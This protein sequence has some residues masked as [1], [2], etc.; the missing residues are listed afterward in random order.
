MF[1]RILALLLWLG[2]APAFAQSIQG[3]SPSVIGI[4]GSNVT[5]AKVLTLPQVQ[6]TVIY[7]TSPTPSPVVP[8][9][10][11]VTNWIQ[12]NG[13]GAVLVEA[14]TNTFS[15]YY[16]VQFSNNPTPVSTPGANLYTVI[17]DASTYASGGAGGETCN[18][19]DMVSDGYRWMRFVAQPDS[20]NTG[21]LNFQARLFG[22]PNTGDA[23]RTYLP[24]VVWKNAEVLV[25][26][27]QAGAGTN[28]YD[29]KLPHG[30]TGVNIYTEVAG[31][32]GASTITTTINEKDP[33]TGFLQPVGVG[34]AS[35]VAGFTSIIANSGYAAPYPVATPP[36]GQTILGLDLPT[37]LVIQDGYT[38]TGSTTITQTIVPVK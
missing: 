10:T 16:S 19:G 28:Y 2:G 38:G 23:V 17:R 20:S 3:A 27:V 13:N 35:H 34:A 14:F 15:G 4:D 31:V 24:G 5:A 8:Q 37:D 29:Y 25:N 21:T 18:F 6:P 22:N 30:A 36:A 11:Q 33:Q 32:S 1:K 26:G 12:L 9:P 7:N